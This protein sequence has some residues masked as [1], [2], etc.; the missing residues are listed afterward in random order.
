M[1]YCIPWSAIIRAVGILLAS[2]SLAQQPHPLPELRIEE[3]ARPQASVPRPVRKLRAV[4]TPSARSNPQRF[5]ASR[6]ITRRVTT[7]SSRTLPPSVSEGIETRPIQQTTAGPVVG[8]KAITSVSAT[9]TDLPVKSMP[10]SIAVLPRLTMERQGTS[11][12]SEAA[13]NVASVVTVH[14]LTFGQISPKIRG[15]AAER[16]IDGINNYYDAGARDLLINAERIEIL[17]GPQ[18]VLFSGGTTAASGAINVISRLP[19][20][21]TSSEFGLTFGSSRH[22]SPVFDINRPLNASGTALFR[23]TG[24][25]EGARSHVE[26]MAS[27][28]YSLNP[29]FLFTNK[30]GTTLTLQ[31]NFSR[32]DQQD[33]AGLPAIGTVDRTAFSFRRSL[34]PAHPA[35][36]TTKS[37]LASITARLEHS[38]DANWSNTT[39]LRYGQSKLFQPSQGLI[40]TFP[41]FGS[42]FD[43]YN[44]MLDY[45]TRDLT[46]AS[47]MKGRFTKGPITSILFMGVDYN[48][49]TD[50]G[51]F[52]GDL[53]P[54]PTDFVGGAFPEY[55]VADTLYYNWRN[56][57]AQINATAHAQVSIASRLH[58]LAGARL[59]RFQISDTDLTGTRALATGFARDKKDT[60]LLL[61]RL[62]ISYDLTKSIAVFAGFSKGA[63]PIPVPF[64]LQ[65]MRPEENTQLEAGI[66]LDIGSGLSGAISAF[67]VIRKRVPTTSGLVTTQSGEHVSRGIEADLLY[68][69]SKNWAFIGSMAVIEASVNKDQVVERIGQTIP[70]VPKKSGRLWINYTIDE[71]WAKGLSIG[72]G[73]YGATGQTIELGTPWRTQG[74]ATFDAALEYKTVDWRVSLAAKNIAN[75]RYWT[76]F[77]YLSGRVAPG[78][79]RAITGTISR[80]F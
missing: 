28:S 38:F 31:G 13:T 26:T 76:H 72:A 20:E 27:K 56:A 61:P 11:S 40:S 10:V 23:F 30:A 43:L 73:I 16:L 37:S 62:G 80:T 69:P 67:H 59:A 44:L 66:K 77:E 25:Y 39:T 48:R 29:T 57:Y 79:P 58:L 35:V 71:G 54:T 36:P 7:D 2:D 49:V 6:P 60:T 24:Q 34:F 18:A 15:F 5:V 32:R 21:T 55:K 50:T 65:L 3:N 64:S 8:Y 78:V 14:P 51:R 17:K 41:T 75:A 52:P 74:Y 46:I 9:H 1:R 45:K 22:V 53:L 12:V 47:S 42:S 33:Y 63:R 70:G 19:V 4:R 68:Q